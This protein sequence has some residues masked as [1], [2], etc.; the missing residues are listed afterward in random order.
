[1]VLDIGPQVYVFRR[2]RRACRSCSGRWSTGTAREGHVDLG[3]D[4][5]EGVMS[6]QCRTLH[7]VAGGARAAMAWRS[8][9]PPAR[10]AA[11]VLVAFSDS[12]R[13]VGENPSS[14]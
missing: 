2:A 7:S 13:S 9:S 6:C 11:L 4:G 1:M 3:G 14:P 5:V 12:G 8:W 10:S